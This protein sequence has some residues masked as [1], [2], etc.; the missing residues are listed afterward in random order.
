MMNA[1]CGCR[2]TLCN[3]TTGGRA[4]CPPTPNA[5]PARRRAGRPSVWPACAA[6]GVESRLVEWQFQMKAMTMN[7][8]D[9]VN[10]D[11]IAE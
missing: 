11:E 3:T 6:S 7:L 5:C 10:E 1:V 4:T 2:E 9:K 8:E